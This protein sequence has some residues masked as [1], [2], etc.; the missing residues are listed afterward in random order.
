MVASNTIPHGADF[1][2][3]FMSNV[4]DCA[5]RETSE[6]IRHYDAFNTGDMNA[7]SRI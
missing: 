3:F 5:R 2:E 6:L 4:D 7:C 1:M